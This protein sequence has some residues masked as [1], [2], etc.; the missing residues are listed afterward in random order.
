MAL[1]NEKGDFFEAIVALFFQEIA[2]SVATILIA[3]EKD[4]YGFEYAKI[5]IDKAQKKGNQEGRDLD[6][7]FEFK[8]GSLVIEIPILVECKSD[9]SPKSFKELD[10]GTKIHQIETSLSA[11]RYLSAEQ[12]RG[13]SYMVFIPLGKVN[14]NTTFSSIITKSIDQKNSKFPDY[15]FEFS[16]DTFELNMFSA[17]SEFANKINSAVDSRSAKLFAN[18]I[19]ILTNESEINS[20]KEKV[21]TFIAGN[22]LKA[23]QAYKSNYNRAGE[24]VAQ[25]IQEKSGSATLKEWSLKAQAQVLSTKLIDKVN[26]LIQERKSAINEEILLAEDMRTSYLTT[27]LLIQYECS[28]Y[29]EKIPLIESHFSE[30]VKVYPRFFATEYNSFQEIE[31]NVKKM[32]ESAKTSFNRFDKGGSIIPVYLLDGSEK[33]LGCYYENMA[34]GM[35]NYEVSSTINIKYN[36]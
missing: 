25:V 35:C 9:E 20:L 30:K 2:S 26:I 19:S 17:F 28:F 6:I 21:I 16:V 36:G 13:A 23:Y 1:N 14:K 31:E 27:R 11:Q 33:I 18:N 10:L 12:Y 29:G 34:R 3:S 8:K 5:S 4:L 15:Y 22:L 24:I 7:I 32:Y